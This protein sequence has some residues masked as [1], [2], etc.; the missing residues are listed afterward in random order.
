[1]D[2]IS[3]TDLANFADEALSPEEM[4]R[5]ELALRTSATLRKRLD[6]IRQARDRGWHS[7]GATWRGHRLSCPTRS[8]LGS[9]LLDALD[10]Q[11]QDYIHFHTEVVGCRMCLANLVD[12]R[13]LQEDQVP[14]TV[15][16]RQ[17]LF[18]SSAGHLKKRK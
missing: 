9:Y 5:V 15:H 8:Q 1:V 14:V 3:D 18:H 12:L 10:P 11:W 13:A 7:V 17:R 2:E 16:R 4:V 6:G